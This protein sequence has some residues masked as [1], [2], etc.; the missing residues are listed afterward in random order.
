MN[1]DRP[2]NPQTPKEGFLT[3]KVH[4]NIIFYIRSTECHENSEYIAILS[5]S[6][7]IW[8]KTF[9]KSRIRLINQQ[10]ISM[11]IALASS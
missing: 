1:R 4:Q 2:T 3:Y 11:K 9:E 7:D 6:G 8:R 10:L 5:G